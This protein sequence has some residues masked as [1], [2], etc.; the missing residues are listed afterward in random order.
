MDW[1]GEGE[2]AFK[3]AIGGDGVPFGKDDQAVA[4]LVSFLN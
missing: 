1:F 3:V 4:W 2:G